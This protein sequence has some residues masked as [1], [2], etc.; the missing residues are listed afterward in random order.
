MK[1]ELSEREFQKIGRYSRQRNAPNTRLQATR[2]S[3]SL[4]SR[5]AER[6]NRHVGRLC[7]KAKPNEQPN[8]MEDNMSDQLSA[9]PVQPSMPSS[10]PVKLWTPR[11][12]GYTTFFLGFPGGIV[13]TALNWMRMG[14]T[15]KAITHLVGGAVGLLALVIVLILLP[16]SIGTWFGLFVNLGMLF[17]LQNQTKKDIEAFKAGNHEV[18]NAH[19]FGG[20]LIGLVMAG[21]WFALAFVVTFFLTLIG[22]PIPK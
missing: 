11:A 22:V 6:L 7:H 21:L 19:W 14:L 8:I 9:T 18:Q 5:L 3:R 13:L 1:A 17:Y 15:N 10:P 20:C 2:P 4:R 12:V 16:G